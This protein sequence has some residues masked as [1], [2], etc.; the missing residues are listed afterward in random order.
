MVCNCS[1][2]EQ[3]VAEDIVCRV[4]LDLQ[5]PHVD[6]VGDLPGWK[7]GQAVCVSFQHQQ[8]SSQCVPYSNVQQCL[9]R[10]YESKVEWGQIES[11][12][13]RL[14][15]SEV[16]A[17]SDALIHSVRKSPGLP[18]YHAQESNHDTETDATW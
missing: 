6:E 8:V 2:W 3:N 12:D 13:P 7:L 17:D 5:D 10:H 15:A 18:N 9:Y 16:L 4:H 11:N 14:C 1:L